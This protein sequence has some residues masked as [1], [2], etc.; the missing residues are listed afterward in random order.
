MI[1]IA[2]KFVGM[3]TVPVKKMERTALSALRIVSAVNNSKKIAQTASRGGVT[4]N[5]T[6]KKMV[7]PVQTARRAL[8]STAAVTAL[9]RERKRLETV[10]WTVAALPTHFAMTVK[11]AQQISAVW[12]P[13]CAAIYGPNVD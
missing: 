10:R 12:E 2:R 11:T 13:D 7:R 6:R 5:A 3:A 4:G 9:V 1:R 8:N